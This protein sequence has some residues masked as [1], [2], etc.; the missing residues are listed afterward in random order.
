MPAVDAAETTLHG[1]AAACRLLQQMDGTCWGVCVTCHA[2]G[3]PFLPFDIY[4][5]GDAELCA[6]CHPEKVP[7]QGD[8]A[9]LL[10]LVGGRG[11]NHAVNVFYDPE[12]SRRLDP[13][14]QGPKLFVDAD[15]THPKVQ[16]S[17]CHDSMSAAPNLLRLS[18]RGSALCL[19]CHRK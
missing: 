4:S 16:C 11:G 5:D 7:R 8:N 1:A 3:D 13:A 14:P 19:A 9:R 10:N 6:R 18:N 15:G 17:T 2:D 12:S